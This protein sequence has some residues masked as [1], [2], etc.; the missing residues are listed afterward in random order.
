VLS[1]CCSWYCAA[2]QLASRR[3]TASAKKLRRLRER[4]TPHAAN[5]RSLA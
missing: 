4:R 2:N 1:A 5:R 3:H